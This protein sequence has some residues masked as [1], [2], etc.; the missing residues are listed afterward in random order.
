MLLVCG[1]AMLLAC[2]ILHLGLGTNWVPPK[3]VLGALRD[4]DKTNFDHVVIYKLR[5]PRAL[6]AILAGG[7]LAVAG[8]L[9]Q[10]VTR[11]PLADPGLLGLTS[12]AAFTVVLAAALWEGAA[13]PWLPLTA[14]AGAVAAAAVVWLVARLMGGTGKILSLVLAGAAVSAFLSSLIACLQL[15]DQDKFD[16]VRIWLTGAIIGPRV[17]LLKWVWPAYLLGGVLAALVARRLTALAMGEEVARSLGMQLN[18]VRFKAMTAVVCLTASVVVL[19]G[20]MG[21][22]GLVVP[23]AMRLMIGADYR[24]LVPC[25]ALGGAI[26][27]LLV[28]LVARIILPPFEISTGLITALVGAPLFIAVVRARL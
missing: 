17:T 13:A 6:L 2:F 18:Q 3:T 4:F 14:G 20:P 16:A 5:L 8:V 24:Y 26:Y 1:M 9:M 22:V 12:G 7:G 28:D 11:N 19:V 21:F 27:L 25:C 23:H 10:G 15:L